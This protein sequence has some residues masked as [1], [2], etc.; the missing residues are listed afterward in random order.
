MHEHAL[1]WI[2]CEFDVKIN[3]KIVQT[4][5][6]FSDGGGASEVTRSRSHGCT[7]V[8][9]IESVRSV[10]LYCVRKKTQAGLLY[11]GTI[12]SSTAGV[13]KCCLQCLP[14]GFAS[15]YA[16]CCRRDLTVDDHQHHHLMQCLHLNQM[17]LK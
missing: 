17:F 13:V 15:D 7:H 10:C 2:V 4:W 14:W 1:R 11:W 6:G 3:S 12:S 9:A 5:I 16:P 8:I